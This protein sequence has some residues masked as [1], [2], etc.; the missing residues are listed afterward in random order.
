MGVRKNSSVQNGSEAFERHGLAKRMSEERLTRSVY[1][2]HEESRMVRGR[3]SLVFL[4]MQLRRSAN[5]RLL[6]QRGVKYM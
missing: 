4:S 5:I 6:E 1:N 2:P 3:P